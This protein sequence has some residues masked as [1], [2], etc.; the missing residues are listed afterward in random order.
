MRREDSRA[1][2]RMIHTVFGFRYEGQIVNAQLGKQLDD[3]A[4][5]REKV[6]AAAIETDAEVVAFKRKLML[7]DHVRHEGVADLKSAHR[8]AVSRVVSAHDLQHFRRKDRSHHRSIL[9][10]RIENLHE[11]SFP[12][13]LRD[14]YIIHTLRADKGVGLNFIGAERAERISRQILNISLVRLACLVVS[15]R[16]GNRQIVITI[17]SRDFFYNVLFNFNVLSDGRCGHIQIIA[18]ALH[19]HFQTFKIVH[20]LVSRQVDAQHMVDAGNSGVYRLWLCDLRINIHAAADDCACA[21][22][23]NQLA[24]SVRCS[25]TKIRVDALFVTSGSLGSQYQSL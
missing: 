11:A 15:F 17:K 20:H 24:D 13:I 4:L 21:D 19:D 25:F 8:L 6:I 3:H 16:D 14:S 22:Q 1:A 18:V 2:T 7:V 12:G 5:E 23:L 10:E 9:T